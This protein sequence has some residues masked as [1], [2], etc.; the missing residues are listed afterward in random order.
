MDVV[1]QQNRNNAY[2]AYLPTF[3]QVKT[4]AKFTVPVVALACIHQVVQAQGGGEESSSLSE[5]D[6]VT[7]LAKSAITALSNTVLKAAQVGVGISYAQAISYTQ[8]RFFNCSTGS[9]SCNNTSLQSTLNYLCNPGKHSICSPLIGSK[10]VERDKVLNFAQGNV[11]AR[12][13]A[14]D[15][16]KDEN[17]RL[18][19]LKHKEEADSIASKIF[20]TFIDKYRSSG[21]T[22]ENAVRWGNSDRLSESHL[23]VC[24]GEN[25]W[26]T[27]NIDLYVKNQPSMSDSAHYLPPKLVAYKELMRI[28]EIK[29][30][31]S[32]M[33]TQYV[34]EKS[35]SRIERELW[36]AKEPI[37]KILSN[38][39]TLIQIDEIFKQSE[40]IPLNEVVDYKKTMP[41]G[42]IANFYRDLSIKYDSLSEALI[43]KESMDFLAAELYRDFSF[44][45]YWMKKIFS[46]LYM[47]RRP[48]GTI[49]EI[50]FLLSLA[51]IVLVFQSRN[52]H[53]REWLHLVG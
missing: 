6:Q 44:T 43:S 10:S 11:I 47:H 30:Y 5:T 22:E 14:L 12:Q 19:P 3:H 4:F 8:G 23:D 40:Q 31:R 37:R 1:N 33:Y 2:F 51:I 26:N 39:A 48:A 28:E 16:S 41:L 18:I 45:F 53:A 32:S 34:I 9:F 21:L 20:S 52:V 38:L 42:K 36:F 50:F 13:F 7:D 49:D 29:P 46:D 15:L 25:R 35:I 24:D 27:W 17:L